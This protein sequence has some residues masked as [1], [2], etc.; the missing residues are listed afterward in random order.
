[1]AMYHESA[2]LSDW[3]HWLAS[4]AAPALVIGLFIIAVGSA[5]IGYV[6]SVFV[7][8]WW[9]GRKWR[10]RAQRLVAPGQ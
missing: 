7:W 2:P 8:R 4:D 1:M 5:V 6:I 9:V 10:R 3:L